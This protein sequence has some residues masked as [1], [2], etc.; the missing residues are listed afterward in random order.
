MSKI[1]GRFDKQPTEV[2]DYD[3]D[4]TEWVGTRTIAPTAHVVIVPTGIT[5]VSS[6]LAGNVVRVV[7]SGGTTGTD[8]KI[9]VRTTF[10]NGL[11][12]EADFLVK[13]KEV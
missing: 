4:Y 11:V 7:L 6:G 1:L 8:Y 13:V 9:T 3:V 10:D 12:K 5:L 2:L